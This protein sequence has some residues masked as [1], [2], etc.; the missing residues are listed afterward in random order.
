MVPAQYVSVLEKLAGKGDFPKDTADNVK[1]ADDDLSSSMKDSRK[2]IND[3][4]DN[5][6]SQSVEKLFPG[7]TKK[8]TSSPLL[9]VAFSGAFRHARLR[10]TAA[11]IGV[12]YLGFQDELDKIANVPSIPGQAGGGAAPLPS[13]SGFKS[14]VGHVGASGA[15]AGMAGGFGKALGG[16]GKVVT[17]AR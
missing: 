15:G 13:M 14:S 12:M 7:K 9:K 11:Q 17:G 10:K 16:I 8:V 3:L 1:S 5:T 2:S 6:K 4:F